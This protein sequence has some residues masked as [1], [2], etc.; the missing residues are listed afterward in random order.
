[1]ISIHKNRYLLFIGVYVCVYDTY[2]ILISIFRLLIFVFHFLFCIIVTKIALEKERNKFHIWIHLLLSHISFSVFL[3]HSN[4]IKFIMLDY[5]L[6]NFLSL[7][8]KMASIA[9]HY[10]PAPNLS[11]FIITVLNL[12]YIFFSSI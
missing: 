4:F 1:M 8:N 9:T 10:I 11:S 5:Y 6:F 7:F 2:T 3:V 12:I